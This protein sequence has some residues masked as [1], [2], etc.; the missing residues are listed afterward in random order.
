MS[1]TPGEQSRRA[2]YGRGVIEG[3][4]MAGVPNPGDFMNASKLA[5]LESSL[6]ASARKVLDAVPMQEPWSK[7]QIVAE[8]KRQGR[9]ATPEVVIGCLGHL[10]ETGLIK[11]PT[12]GNFIRVPAR[13]PSPTEKELPTVPSTATPIALQPVKAAA[14]AEVPD[15]LTR[16]AN[17]GALLRRAADEVDSLALDVEERVR[18][19]GQGDEE[20]RKMKAVL[21]KILD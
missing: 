13:Q 21:K 7:T 19:A 8:L 14:Q 11:E 12:R 2:S 4:R 9:S 6:N 16:L 15:T 3:L 5:R 17:L 18:V 1:V 20:L 10:T